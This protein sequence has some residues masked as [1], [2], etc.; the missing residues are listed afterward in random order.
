MAKKKEATKDTSTV[1]AK[2]AA[3]IAAEVLK[4]NPD[5]KEVH[6]T[7]DGTAFYGRNDA[8][9]HANTLQNREVYS[10]KRGVVGEPAIP[11]GKTAEKVI[12]DDPA[13][14][15]IDELGGAKEEPDNTNTPT[16]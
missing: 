5:I 13:E 9:N 1:A 2:A 8:Q 11:D 10:M 12:I 7:S 3:K 4:L 14:D 15:D 16:E 6:V